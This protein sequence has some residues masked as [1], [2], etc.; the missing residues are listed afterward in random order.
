MVEPH[1]P[2]EPHVLIVANPSSG[3]LANRDRVA[4]LVDSLQRHGLTSQTIWEPGQSPWRDP[5]RCVVAAGGDGTVA[6]MANMLKSR[7]PDAAPQ[8]PLAILPLGNQNLL[9]RELGFV[10]EPDRLATAIIAAR[11][12]RIDLGRTSD[13]WFTVMLSAG[14]DAD[15]ALRLARWRGDD[16]QM[17][18][19][20]N[21][22]Y[23]K[24][25]LATVARYGFGLMDLEADGVTC[26]RGA[27]ALVFNVA[28]YALGLPFVQGASD[29]DGLLHWVVF[30]KP[31]RLAALSYLAAVLR[32][33]HLQ[34]RDVHH[35]TAGRIRLLSEQ[36]VPVQID[37]DAVGFTPV[38]VELEPDALAVLD[39]TG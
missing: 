15:V 7:P 14:L 19:V 26:C 31:G 22:S 10:V 29:D 32:G 16:Q 12:R 18:R 38:S 24:P 5:C 30:E 21:A 27:M 33:K 35:G 20:G 9:A 8:P 1:A 37:G 6:A 4:A 2:A 25:I 17:R 39:M 36:S 11:V 28:R 3:R 13:R 34:R 23:V